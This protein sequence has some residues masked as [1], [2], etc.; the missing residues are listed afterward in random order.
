MPHTDKLT[1]R[2][3]TRADL[4]SLVRMEQA[5]FPTSLYHTMPRRQYLHMLTR[6]HGDVLVMVLGDT[7]IASAIVLYR[8]GSQGARLYSIAVSPAHGGQNHGTRFLDEI[9]RRLAAQG[10]QTLSSEFRADLTR[11]LAWYTA[12]GFN[13]TA[14][15]PAYYPDGCAGIRVKKQLNKN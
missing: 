9:E 4:D 13:K 6:A 8:K 10:Y 3:A 12:R 11:Y 1:M 7:V 14:T 2:K 15:L 5:C